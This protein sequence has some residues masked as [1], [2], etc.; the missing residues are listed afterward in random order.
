MCFFF[1]P[2]LW[3]YILKLYCPLVFC[4]GT[5]ALQLN[6]CACYFCSLIISFDFYLKALE[7]LDKEIEFF[8]KHYMILSNYLDD[9]IARLEDI[10]AASLKVNIS[11]WYKDIVPLE[12][13]S[14]LVV[15]IF[16]SLSHCHDSKCISFLFF[17]FWIHI[18]TVWYYFFFQRFSTDLKSPLNTDAKLIEVLAGSIER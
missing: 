15:S 16:S 6:V 5:C 17:G 3:K 9:A 2:K 7:K 12:I 18:Y 11:F 13:S 10:S 4:A 14:Y 8:C 1:Q